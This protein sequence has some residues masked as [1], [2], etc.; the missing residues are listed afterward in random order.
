MTTTPRPRTGG[1]LVAECL[2]L[3]GA[4]TV[5]TV[6]GESFLAVLD[7]LYDLRDTVRLIVC[8]HEAGAAN[9]AEAHGKL[10][11]RPGVVMVTRGPGATQ[12]SVG[13]HTAHQD[14]TPMLFLIGQIERDARDREGFQE[15]DVRRMFGSLAKWATEIDS[16]RRV[17]EIMGRAF[18][19]AM[20]GRPGPVVIGLPEDM[21]TEEATVPLGDP[22]HVVRP[23]PSTHDLH[24]MQEL[25]RASRSPVMIVGGGGWS[26]ET[27]TDV[28]AFAEANALPI[29]ASFRCQDYVDNLH[30]CYAGHLGLGTDAP[31]LARIRAADLLLVVGAR[32]GEI[33]TQGYTL[34]DVPRPRQRLVHVHPGAEELGRVFQADV[35]I[36]AGSAEF[37]A[38]A[39]R[40]DPVDA[41][42]WRAER[43]EAHRDYL[44]TLEPTSH[45]G[46]LQMPAVMALLN[47]R[48]PD[49]IVTNGAGNYTG[50]VHRYWRFRRY[51]TQ[52]APTSG[53]MGYG[54]P[55]AIAAKLVAPARPVVSMNGDG[56]F[57]MCG[58]ELSTAVRYGLDPLFLVVNNGMY[59]TIRMHQE[60][61]FPA[62]VH[63][64][65]LV[66]PDF[67]AYA[68]AFG[69]HAEL[70]EKTADVEPALERAL[71][72]GRAALLELRVDPDAITPR[73]TLTAIRASSLARRR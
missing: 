47:E 50:W 45:P 1:Q 62:R 17:P 34:L 9:M 44:R 33:T 10:T 7:A 28:M 61:E 36:N 71:A 22:Y 46:S 6:P 20:A 66:N 49:A 42:G 35:P 65:E 73:T 64:T 41:S 29:V 14:S 25:L 30:P 31:L 58:Q 59:G 27:A 72:S 16:A 11:G 18:Q 2:R 38:A 39:R 43:D 56:C 63:G 52:V 3:H 21:L 37:A 12:G 54:V 15:I 68:R 48:L 70:V 24:R 8:R 53:A 60:R 23:A 32:L 57:L 51:R 13:V 40:L 4:D 26:A 5:F 55:A 69:A 67:V 19:T